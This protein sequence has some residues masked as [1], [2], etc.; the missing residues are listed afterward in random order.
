VITALEHRCVTL[1]HIEPPVAIASAAIER[2][3][4][5]L[6]RV[7]D[8]AEIGSVPCAPIRDMDVEQGCLRERASQRRQIITH[9]FAEDLDML[10]LVIEHRLALAGARRKAA[11][12]DDIKLRQPD[13]NMRGA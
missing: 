12:D 10:A 3:E 6:E 1:W 7:R 9:S 4:N 13:L 5:R 11:S 8:R 2:R